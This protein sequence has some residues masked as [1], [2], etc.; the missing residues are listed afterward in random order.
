M[1]LGKNIVANIIGRIWSIISIYVFVPI[2]IQLL[3]VESYGVITFYTVMLTILSFAD[4]GLTATLNREFARVKT[5]DPAYKQNLLR[6]FEYIYLLICIFLISAVFFGAHTIVDNFIKSDTILF[7]DLVRHVRIMGIIVS[8][9]LVSSLYN[10]G[11][12]GLQKQV[13][14][15]ALMVIYS[16][17]RSGLV[18]IPLIWIQ[19][20]NV[21]F[22]WQI[23]S[24]VLY[25][26]F[27]RY[28]LCRAIHIKNIPTQANLLYLKN[29]WKY[30]VGMVMMAV[31]YATNTQV[32]KLLVGN[33][34][35]LKYFSYYSLAAMV[36]QGVLVL[37][38]PIG[39][40]F[41]PE[42]T[43]LI[44]IKDYDKSKQFYHKIAYLIAA[45]TSSLSV[46]FVFYAYDYIKIWTGDAVIAE[47]I[48][49]ATILLTM[50]AMFMSIQL[51]PYYL[52]LSNGHTHTNVI[53]GI[54]TIILIVPSLQFLIPKFG[55]LGA[56]I[57]WFVINFTVT[58]LLAYIVMKKFMTGEFKRWLLWD[59]L[60]PILISFGV[61]GPLYLFSKL[62]PSGIYNVIYG[63]IIV[64]SISGVNAYVLTRRYPEILTHPIVVRYI[65]KINGAITINRYTNT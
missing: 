19:D 1:A 53:M 42:L 45:V 8:L 20:L 10:G 27:L 57:P 52:A 15:N 54:M 61:G 58:T 43:R 30:A 60:L 32:D 49:P 51:C 22:Y 18:V 46:I 12:M 4:A 14:S 21:Y 13:L 7:D 50:G 48:A 37:A 35:S 33:L 16:V 11:L 63:L 24:S 40:A 55:L 26:I 31:I 3:G 36:G 9:S 59:S 62:L 2:Y 17:L 65:K 39:V 34:L 25:F 56:A 64:V 47:A 41:F 29:I 28:Y 38:T 44:S 23:A 6:T 5:D